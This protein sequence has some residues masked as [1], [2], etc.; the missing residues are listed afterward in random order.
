MYN[1]KTFPLTY[2]KGDLLAVTICPD[3]KMQ[4]FNT[5]KRYQDF[6]AYY[7]TKF[8][9]LFEDSKQ[10]QFY[11][12]LELSE[13]IGEVSGEG[14]RLHF[15]GCI[16]LC[17]N[18]SVFRWLNDVMPDLLIHSRLKIDHIKDQ[19]YM[20]GWYQYCHKQFVVMPTNSTISN[21]DWKHLSVLE[22]G[23]VELSNSRGG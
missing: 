23:L 22:P 21:T 8:N 12:R 20:D 4:G 5:P 14:P 19:A 3:D 11:F 13:P 9:R 16:K 6:L 18:L 10:F 15:H 1:E 7:N 17:T 2:Q